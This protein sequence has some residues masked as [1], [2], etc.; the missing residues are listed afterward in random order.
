M[1]GFFKTHIILMKNDTEKQKK[2]V[3]MAVN[4][5]RTGY[6]STTDRDKMVG[7]PVPDCPF[8]I[9]K[10]T[11]EHILWQCKETEEE[12]RKNNKTKELW[13]KEEGTKMLVEYVK[14]FAYYGYYGL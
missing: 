13:K 10:L 7:N 6:S 9:A 3:Q 4:R 2:R 12:K 14:N 11:L 8:C 5:L 1:Q